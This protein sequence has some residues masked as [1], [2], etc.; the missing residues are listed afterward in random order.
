MEM[1]DDEATTFMRS[2]IPED[3]IFHRDPLSYLRRRRATEQW[4]RDEFRKAGGVPIT[5]YPIYLTVGRSTYIEEQGIYNEVLEFPLST[6]DA[7]SISFTYPD[8]YV[9][10]WLTETQS[11]YFKADL[12]GRVFSLTHLPDLISHPIVRANAWKE[13]EHRYDFFLEAQV[14]DWDLLKRT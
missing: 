7:H 12:H 6:F 4:L 11:S 1:S 10:R 8:S 14:W 5:P 3:E 9:S 2:E 13:Q